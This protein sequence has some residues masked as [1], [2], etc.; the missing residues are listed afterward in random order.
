MKREAMPT[1][2]FAAKPK[3]SGL[4]YWKMPRQVG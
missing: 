1:A 2:L 3:T 4:P